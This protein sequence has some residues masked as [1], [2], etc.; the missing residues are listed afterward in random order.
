MA[1]T[2][3]FVSPGKVAPAAP[4]LARAAPLLHHRRTALE[5]LRD[6]APKPE[7]QVNAAQFALIAGTALVAAIG[8]ILGQGL[9]VSSVVAGA[10]GGLGLSLGATR[11]GVLARGAG[12]RTTRSVLPAAM[13]G[14]GVGITLALGMAT[15][16]LL[17]TCGL[18]SLAALYAWRT[19][20]DLISENLLAREIAAARED[21][22]RD[23]AAFADDLRAIQANTEAEVA[24]LCRKAGIDP[25]LLDPVSDPASDQ[26]E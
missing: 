8:A 16:P 25:K 4:E 1:D 20:R 22:D 11:L 23:S 24:R 17:I 5:T 14:I 26:T 19:Q 18:S 10:G 21:L 9:S 15:L 12:L 2:T 3:F 13:T 7:T 6:R